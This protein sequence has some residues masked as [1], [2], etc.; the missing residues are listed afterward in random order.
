MVE[1]M[2]A[3]GVLSAASSSSQCYLGFTCTL[4][5]Y[6]HNGY[7]M[8]DNN[9]NSMIFNTLLGTQ[10]KLDGYT[11]LIGTTGSFPTYKLYCNGNAY[12]NG[13]TTATGTKTFD[14]PHPTKDKHRLRHRC[15]ESPQA[16]LFYRYQYDCN[17]GK[18]EFPMPNYFSTL[19]KDVQVFVSPYNNFG[20]AYGDVSGNILYITASTAGTFNIQVIGTRNDK[21][22]N[23]EF[24]QYGIEY[25]E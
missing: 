10:L 17:V 25:P 4:N 18:N 6:N 15:I 8:Y 9:A 14:I 16:D 7:I 24:D 22:A 20:S 1:G 3:G 19:N 5:A 2:A 23:D 12:F 13:T 11:V 21:A